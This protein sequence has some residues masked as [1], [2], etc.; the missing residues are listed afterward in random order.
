MAIRLDIGYEQCLSFIGG[1]LLIHMDKFKA[2]VAMMNLILNPIILQF[3]TFDE[4]EM[5]KKLQLFK[6]VF[7]FNLSE[8]CERFE[9]L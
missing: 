4:K 3:Y 6:Q 7:Y 8:L 9:N 2:Y 1:I 5:K